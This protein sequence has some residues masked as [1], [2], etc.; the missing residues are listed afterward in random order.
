MLGRYRI[1]GG[2]TKGVLAKGMSGVTF[3]KKSEC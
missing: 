3:D 2:R 1:T